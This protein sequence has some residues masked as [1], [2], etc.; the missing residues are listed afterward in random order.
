MAMKQSFATFTRLSS[1][2]IAIG[3]VFTLFLAACGDDSGSNSESSGAEQTFISDLIVEVFDDLPVCTASRE[4]V[5]AYVKEEKTAY[6]CSN[7]EWSKDDNSIYIERIE[8]SSSSLSSSTTTQS[9][10]SQDKPSSSASSSSSQITESSSSEILGSSSSENSFSSDNKNGELVDSRDGQ[11]YKTV[12]IGSQTWMAQNLNYEAENSYCYD[13]DDSYCAMYGRLYT[14]SAASAACPS[15]WHLPSKD[16]WETL[17]ATVGGET[18]AATTLKST[19]GWENEGIGSNESGFSCLPAGYRDIR[20]DFGSVG[21]IAALWSSTEAE[22][23]KAYNICLLA[24]SYTQTLIYSQKAGFSVRCLKGKAPEQTAGSSASGEVVSSSS[25]AR[26]SSSSAVSS[27]SIPKS[28]SSSSAL[29]SSSS[30][31]SSSSSSVKSSSSIPRSS[32][33]GSETTGFMIDPRDGQ[34]YRIVKIGDYWWMA[35][36]LNYATENSYCY[37]NDESYCTQYGR[38]YT[39]AAAVGKSEDKCGEGHKCSLSEY[40]WTQGVCPT[41]WYIPSKEIWEF[42]IYA[43]GGENSAGR[44]LKSSSG[45]EGNGN[46]TDDFGFSALPFYTGGWD[47]EWWINLGKNAWFWTATEYDNNVAYHTSMYYGNSHAGVDAAEKH[48]IYPVRCFKN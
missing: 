47:S 40:Y 42:L 13:D 25:S 37:K 27:S 1:W 23:V 45:W 19:S 48:V 15:G 31:V 35:Q 3:S 43:A 17:I 22:N 2:S 33:S 16:E 29:S 8:N 11:T 38:S 21:H 18:I 6:V 12:V 39:W 34:T 4:G 36:N 9:C 24:Q 20:E 28:S 14:W 30:A 44:R 5:T 7:G 46:G 26:Y 10:S 41:G 32:S